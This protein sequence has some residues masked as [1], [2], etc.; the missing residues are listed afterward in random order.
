[1]LSQSGFQALE[2]WTI[3]HKELDELLSKIRTGAAP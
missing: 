1:M 3:K 2:A